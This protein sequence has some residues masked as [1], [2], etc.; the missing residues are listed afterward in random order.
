MGK[1]YIV[2]V[3]PNSKSLDSDY[4]HLQ[5]QVTVHLIDKQL[6]APLPPKNDVHPGPAG[7]SSSAASVLPVAP[8]YS[9][10]ATPPSTNLAL[11]K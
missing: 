9:V 6:L 4:Y 11:H 2:T 1:K 7:Q 10:L 8:H 5:V 3:T